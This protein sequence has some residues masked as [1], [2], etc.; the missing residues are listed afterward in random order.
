MSDTSS[1]VVSSAMKKERSPSFPFIPLTKAIERARSIYVA[2]KRHEARM[3]DVANALGSGAKSSGTL[4]TVAALISFGLLDDNGSGENRKFKITDLAFKA[5]E[6]QRPGAKE[7]ALREAALKPRLIAEYA[8][9][10]SEGRPSDAICISILRIDRGFTED[11]A[12]AFLKVFDDAIT[13]AGDS[14]SILNSTLTEPPLPPTDTPVETKLS[15]QKIEVGDIVQWESQGVLRLEA[16]TAV[17]A[18]QEHEG[19][20]WVFVEGSETGIRLDEIVLVSKTPSAATAPPTLAI[21]Q[22]SRNQ[23]AIDTSTM[24]VDRFTVDEGVVRIEFPK[25]M[26]LASVEELAEFF[27][28]FIKK[29]KRRAGSSQS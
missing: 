15:T 17:R 10:W 1:A 22:P 12:K 7:A 13:Y 6:D 3:V 28:L 2:A 5:L 11:G 4:Q 26:G 23:P 18:M 20:A 25:S 21:P 19:Q 16:P 29:A 14:D 24:D 27:Q 9:T 8:E